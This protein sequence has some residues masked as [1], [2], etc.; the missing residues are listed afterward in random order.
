MCTLVFSSPFFIIQTVCV[1]YFTIG[2]LLRLISTPS[3]VPFAL[4]FLGLIDR[5]AI[6]PYFVV[7]ALSLNNRGIDLGG[8]TVIGLRLLRSLRFPRLV[9]MYLIFHRKKFY[10]GQV[11]SP[12]DVS[13]A[14]HDK[15]EDCIR[16]KLTGL[17]RSPS[18]ETAVFHT[19]AV[20]PPP[21]IVHQT[22]KP[23]SSSHVQF[24]ISLTNNQ[25]VDQLM[26]ELT[27]A[28]G[29][30]DEQMHLKLVSDRGESL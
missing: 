10:P 26:R 16:R 17:K 23:S 12:V 28:I 29:I 19:I 27:E 21:P 22:S 13:D 20:H 25:L 15:K 11:I 5:R 4:S 2:F 24:I 8:G 3:Y 6:V 1:S 30:I 9:R 7:L 18:K 14:E